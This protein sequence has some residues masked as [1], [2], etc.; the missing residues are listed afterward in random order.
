MTRIQTDRILKVAAYCRVSTEQEEQQGS[1]KN[2]V[3][4]YTN[5]I[6]ANPDYEMA[7]IFSDDGISGTSTRNGRVSW[8]W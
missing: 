5:L 8:L 6:N 4:Y 3:E 1:F 2:Q 7:G